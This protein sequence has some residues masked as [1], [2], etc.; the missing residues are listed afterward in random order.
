MALALAIDGGTFHLSGNPIRGTITGAVAPANSSEYKALVKITSVDG[1]LIG[2]PFID[3]IAPTGAGVAVFEF[4][5]WVDQ[6]QDKGFDWPLVGG[7]GSDSNYTLDVNFTPGE[8]YFDDDNVFHETWGSASVTH[9]I[10]KGGVSFR[11]LGQYY[12][13]DSSFYEDIVEGGKFLTRQPDN[14]VVHPWQPTKLWLL[15]A[16]NASVSL[17][18][19]AYYEDGSSYLYTSSHTLYINILHEINCLPHHADAINMPPVKNDGTR[20]DYYDVWISGVTENRRFYVDHDYYQNC[21]FLFVAN[22]LGGVD[23]IWLNG[24]ME[25]GFETE[26]VSAIKT[27]TATSGAKN[28]TKVISSRAGRKTWKI[29]TGYKSR[30]EMLGM[31]DVLLSRQVWLLTDANGYNRGVLYP[32]NIKNSSALLNN[33]LED[34]NNLELELEEAHDNAYL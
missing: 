32:V 21:N 23:C 34:L 1:L 5:G 3:A 26:L 18:I 6:P 20:M 15:A 11:E 25:D 8:S 30:D 31:A 13:D 28:R 22:S 16:A 33:S 10:I 7:L 17:K 19:Y 2:G 29:N 4:S 12:D 24:H 9:F 14:L 27:W